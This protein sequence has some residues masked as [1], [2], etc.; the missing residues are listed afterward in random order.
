M[1]AQAP[2]PTAF[3]ESHPVFR[4]EEFVD[5]HAVQGGRSPAT[6]ATVLKHAV[7][8]GRLLHIRRGLYA[9]VPRGV[10]PD[11]ARIDPFLLASRH[12]PDAV[13]AFH[14][15]LQLHGRTYSEWSRVHVWSAHRS[16]PV[17]WRGME[18]VPI[19]LPREL[20]AAPAQGGGIA[21]LH[22]AGGEL[23]VTTLERTLVDV[24]DQPDKGG[25]LEEIWRSL[26]M[27]EFVDPDEIL[28]YTL[29]LGR[30]L[31]AARVGF[32]L[33]QHRDAWFIDDA[34]LATLRAH[35]PKSPT[36]FDSS[37]EPGRLQPAWNLIVPPRVLQ[38][39]SQEVLRR[40]V[41]HAHLTFFEGF[42]RQH[43]S[44]RTDAG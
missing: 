38:R 16:K 20:L 4:T 22:H 37:R 8:A 2:S 34:T 43:V 40:G 36:Y 31:T 15:A 33:E 1:S 9:V 5:F 30:A 23:R 26:E 10:S 7:A 25:G 29:L 19:L 11:R 28:R 14:G 12:T 18:I 42:A 44:R 6:S 32:F 13:V 41:N 27:I 35:A 24:L 17:S 3:Y 39:S 21:R